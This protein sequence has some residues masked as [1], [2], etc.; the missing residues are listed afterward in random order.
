[1]SKIIKRNFKSCNKITFIRNDNMSECDIYL[2]YENMMRV[3]LWNRYAFYRADAMTLEY[4][5]EFDLS[6]A[7]EF[8]DFI[9]NTLRNID[10]FYPEDGIVSEFDDFNATRIKIPYGDDMSIIYKY[11]D[12]KVEFVLHKGI[13]KPSPERL[14]CRH[15]AHYFTNSEETRAYADF[16]NEIAEQVRNIATQD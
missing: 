9:V 15:D 2:D 7:N 6:K 11:K 3:E 16:L 10:A 4:F 12:D 1:M 5:T 8:V 13:H 14:D